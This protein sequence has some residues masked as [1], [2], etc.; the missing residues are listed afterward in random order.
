MQH[1]ATRTSWGYAMR[2]PLECAWKTA[3]H[4]MTLGS[5]EHATNTEQAGTRATQCDA[6]SSAPPC[7]QRYRSGVTRQA[8]CGTLGTHL[9]RLLTRRGRGWLLMLPQ[10]VAVGPGP[11][12]SARRLLS[13]RPLQS[14]AAAPQRWAAAALTGGQP[15]RPETADHPSRVQSKAAAAEWEPAR[16]GT[17]QPGQ[18]Q[19]AMV[20]CT[21]RLVS[22]RNR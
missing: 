11:P 8:C 17:T 9:A 3:K 19:A 2:Q 13:P 10:P 12:A 4:R 20:R 1:T 18:Y 7:N 22:A 15:H 6:C 14:R 21:M 16:T 5:Q